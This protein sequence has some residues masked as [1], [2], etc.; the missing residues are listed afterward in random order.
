MHQTLPV[1]LLL[2]TKL[3]LPLRGRDLGGFGGKSA[4][5]D[6]IEAMN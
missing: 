3:G 1:S 2:F 6:R 5:K 4:A